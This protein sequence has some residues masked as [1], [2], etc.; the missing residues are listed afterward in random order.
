MNLKTEKEILK[1]QLVI[2][3]PVYLKKNFT[4]DDDCAGEVQ[5]VVAQ[6]FERIFSGKS[7]EEL[8]EMKLS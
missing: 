7:E 3:D 4:F 1:G 8:D 6:I 2:S 5:R